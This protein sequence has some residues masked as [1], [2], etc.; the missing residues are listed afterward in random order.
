MSTASFL[1]CMRVYDRAR[2]RGP[3]FT[4]MACQF[5]QGHDGGCSWSEVAYDDQ[6]ELLAEQE[7]E[8]RAKPDALEATL[9]DVL[10]AVEAG[11]CDEY[12]ELILST[13]HGRKLARRGVHGFRR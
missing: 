4:N 12:L 2:M 7:A 8:A 1:M 5:R 11:E 3:R 10:A 9:Q 6:R 13:T